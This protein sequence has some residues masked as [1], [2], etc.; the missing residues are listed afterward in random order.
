MPGEV[1]ANKRTDIQI[2][3]IQIDSIAQFMLNAFSTGNDS[4]FR[5]IKNQDLGALT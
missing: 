1:R 2:N 5:N 3:F 4:N